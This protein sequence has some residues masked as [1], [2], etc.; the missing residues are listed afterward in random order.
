VKL[1]LS[2]QEGSK[3]SFTALLV[4]SPRR[5]VAAKTKVQVYRDWRRRLVVFHDNEL[6]E[7]AV[8]R[9]EIS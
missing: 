4:A 1:D 9:E 3:L 2:A 5:A 7:S 8:L 6:V